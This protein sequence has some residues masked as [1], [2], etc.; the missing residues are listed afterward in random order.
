MNDRSLHADV[1]HNNTYNNLTNQSNQSPYIVRLHQVTRFTIETILMNIEHNRYYNEPVKQLRLEI[2]S[3]K[4][5]F[6]TFN[7]YS[8]N[9][10]L[11]VIITNI[12]II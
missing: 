12:Y 1:S 2:K 3:K 7:S 10:K 11:S 5:Y 4:H 6:S 9:N 8:N